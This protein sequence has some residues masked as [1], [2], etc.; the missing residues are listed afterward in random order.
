LKA[1][2]LALQGG[3]AEHCKALREC[4][5]EALE[6]RSVKELDSCSSLIIPGG[7]S[8]VMAKLLM[9]TGL[10]KEIKKRAGK[11]M[12]VFGTCA[13]AVMLSGKVTAEKRFRP[14]G[15]VD[16]EICRNAY[17]R[18]LESFEAPLLIK[19]IPEPFNGVFIRAPVIKKAGKSVEVLAR[20]G[21]SPVLMK[22]GKIMVCTFH[23]ELEGNPAIHRY[24]LSL[25]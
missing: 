18:Q 24:F 12:P 22:Q 6:V 1:G 8:T 25:L 9:Q 19:G 11:G 2:V 3:F 13:G 10:G 21:K 5:A 17:G 4:G 14:I 15:L 16:A 7:E 23:P 20:H